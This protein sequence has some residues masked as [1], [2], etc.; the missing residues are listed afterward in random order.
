[1]LPTFTT[2]TFENGH[3][4]FYS[5]YE[6]IEANVHHDDIHHDDDHRIGF[7]S[8]QIRNIAD[9]ISDKLIKIV[10]DKISPVLSQKI[11]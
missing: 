3:D 6:R 11:D 2:Q 9:K 7:N 10:E 4:F 1:M 5:K 8:S